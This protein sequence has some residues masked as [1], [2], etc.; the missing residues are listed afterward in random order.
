MNVL[1][2]PLCVAVMALVGCSEVDPASLDQAK[3]ALE[4]LAFDLAAGADDAAV[5]A[6]DAQ[7]AAFVREQPGFVRRVTGFGRH[8]PQG[9][10]DAATR[11]FYVT[12]YWE[13]L[14]AATTAAAAFSR[15]SAAQAARP[16]ATLAHYGHYVIGASAAAGGYRIPTDQVLAGP[17]EAIELVSFDVVDGADPAKV[18]AA[19]VALDVGLIRKQ[20]G[21]LARIGALGKNEVTGATA[22]VAVVYWKTLDNALAAANALFAAQAAMTPEERAQMPNYQKPNTPYFYSHYFDKLA[23]LR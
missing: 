7:T 13:S 1:P 6:A 23:L 22:H 16:G 8:E 14:E 21:Y 20:P 19:D 12:V 2:L 11:Q 18:I 9:P 4:V 5:L 10:M 3:V 15:S 17:G